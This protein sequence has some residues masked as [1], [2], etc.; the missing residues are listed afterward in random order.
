MK[1]N[2]FCWFGIDVSKFVG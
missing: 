2:M 1:N